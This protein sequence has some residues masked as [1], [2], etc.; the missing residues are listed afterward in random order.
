M[1]ESAGAKTF[2]ERS[3]LRIS[4]AAVSRVFATAIAFVATVAAFPALG[5]PVLGAVSVSP[6]TVVIGTPTLVTVKAS[7]TDST[8]IPGSVNLLQVGANGVT[9]ILGQMHDDGVNGDRAAADGIF[10]L[11]T[12][13]S[14]PAVSQVQL[15]VSAAFRGVLQRSRWPAAA[16]W[17]Q[18]PTAP[19]QAVSALASALSSGDVPKA[20]AYVVP[21]PNSLRALQTFNQAQLSRLGGILRAATLTS[22]SPD[23]RVFTSTFP[24]ANGSATT[25]FTLVPAQ[26]GQWV[27]ETW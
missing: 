15:Q 23:L 2:R 8:L 3:G 25:R 1:S 27:I 6:R 10:T 22:A 24:T 4:R 9:G 21:S 13:L 11:I 17:F 16:V 20:M 19:E 7:I 12:S 14:S 18:V 5:A 26:N